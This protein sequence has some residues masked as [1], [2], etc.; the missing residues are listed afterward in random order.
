MAWGKNRKEAEPTVA[1]F[2]RLWGGGKGGGQ[3]IGKSKLAADGGH[4]TKLK[5]H[6]ISNQNVYQPIRLRSLLIL[7]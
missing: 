4:Q 5:I 7:K 1:N 3:G 6:F 2:P